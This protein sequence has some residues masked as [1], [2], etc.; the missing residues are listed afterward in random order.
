MAEKKSDP[1]K[2]SE[3]T[4]PAEAQEPVV[5]QAALSPSKLRSYIRVPKA[6]AG[7]YLSARFDDEGNSTDLV[8]PEVVDALKKDFPGINIE[9]LTTEAPSEVAA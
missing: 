1:E 6:L 5:K 8:S 7:A 3:T 2:K 9:V 4:S